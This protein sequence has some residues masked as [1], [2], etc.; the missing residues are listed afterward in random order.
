M[1][2][3][4]AERLHESRII[5]RGREV[6]RIESESVA[7]M[8]GRL[9]S[10]FVRAVETIA[11]ISGRVVVTGIGKS[12]HVARKLASTLSSTGTPAAFLHSA[13]ATLEDVFVE[14]AGRGLA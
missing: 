5:E 12:G 8:A 4:S 2:D 10:P 3:G 13:E 1:S 14:Y 9:G 6:L 7:S 11:S